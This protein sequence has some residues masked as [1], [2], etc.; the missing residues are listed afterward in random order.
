MYVIINDECLGGFAKCSQTLMWLTN[1]GSLST[2]FI[3]D[4]RASLR[5]AQSDEPH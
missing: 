2:S 1:R 5:I 4:H 3:R